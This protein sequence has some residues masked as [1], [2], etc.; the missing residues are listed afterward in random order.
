MSAFHDEHLHRLYFLVREEAGQ[1]TGLVPLVHDIENDRHL[2]YGGSNRDHKN[3]GKLLNVETIQEACRRK[4]G[5]I[6]CMT[7][8]QWKAAWDMESE[9]CRTMRKPPLAE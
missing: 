5:E 1:P 6:N 4:V 3:L 2:L 7:G 9:T 8:M